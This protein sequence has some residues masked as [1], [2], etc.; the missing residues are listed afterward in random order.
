MLT[1][2]VNN[3]GVEE[4][5]NIIDEGKVNIKI[6]NKGREV[7]KCLIV[8]IVWVAQ[9]IKQEEKYCEEGIENEN[10]MED[11]NEEVELENF[12]EEIT[13]RYE[14]TGIQEEYEMEIDDKSQI[15]ELLEEQ[16]EEKK[17]TKAYEQLFRELTVMK[18]EEEDN[19]EEQEN[20]LTDLVK[21]AIKGDQRSIG[22]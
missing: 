9:K 22:K 17:N 12:D 14:D 18:G 5:E 11:R 21:E 15:E 20:S 7:I 3:E 1:I 4:L 2:E 8:Q 16:L 19:I 10:E 6:I 13:E